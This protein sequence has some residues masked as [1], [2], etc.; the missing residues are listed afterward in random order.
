MPDELAFELRYPDGHWVRMYKN[1]RVDGVPKGTIIINWVPHL[2]NYAQ[3]LRDCHEAAQN[4][5]QPDIE[6]EAGQ[7]Q[8]RRQGENS[9]DILQP[10]YHDSH[11]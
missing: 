6:Q 5:R 4:N 11:T 10:L 7:Q 3:A 1:G 9:D 2:L 8:L